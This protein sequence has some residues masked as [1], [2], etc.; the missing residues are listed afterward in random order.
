MNTS[1][2]PLINY[3][4]NGLSGKALYLFLMVPVLL[5]GM[6]ILI[7]D[8]LGVC[9]LPVKASSAVSDMVLFFVVTLITFSL[10]DG[11]LP[12]PGFL[13]SANFDELV[14]KV[15]CSGLY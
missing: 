3:L 11:R 5:M 12:I 10:I 1:I 4:I 2:R 8:A 7:F 9:G 6:R 15:Y 13:S 14:Q